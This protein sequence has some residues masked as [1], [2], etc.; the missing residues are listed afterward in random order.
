MALFVAKFRYAALAP[1]APVATHLLPMY[2]AT[3]SRA[4][5]GMQHVGKLVFRANTCNPESRDKDGVGEL[6]FSANTCNPASRDTAGSFLKQKLSF[7]QHLPPQQLSP[8]SQ[9]VLPPQH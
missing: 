5:P 9:H 3:S 7:P 1:V 8:E 4:G 2:F 6:V